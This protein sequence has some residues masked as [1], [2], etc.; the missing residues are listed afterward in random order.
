MG[1]DP[2]KAFDEKAFVKGAYQALIDRGVITE[3][4]LTPSTVTDE[5]LDAFEQEYDVKMPSLLRVYLGTVKELIFTSD[6]SKS[7]YAALSSI[8]VPQYASF[9]RLA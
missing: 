8:G 7:S 2:E 3:D 5:M 1:S 4:L 9:L 6:L